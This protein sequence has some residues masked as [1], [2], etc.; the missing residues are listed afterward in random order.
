MKSRA[1]IRILARETNP[2]GDLFARLMADLFV[3]LG[4]N[5][6]RLNVHKT[7]RELDLVASHRL[8]RRRAIAEC[9]A[10]GDPIGGA[11][12]NKFV[13]ALDAEQDDDPVTGYFVSLGGFTETALEQERQR[14]KTKLVLLDGPQIVDQLI[15]GRILIPKELATNLAGRLAGSLADVALDPQMELLGHERGWFWAVYYLHFQTRSHFA[16]IRSDGEFASREIADELIAADRECGG[17]LHGLKILNPDTSASSTDDTEKAI[18]AYRRY[19][20]SECGFIQLDG[21]PADAE[22]A[23]HHLKLEALF[24]P[25]YLDILRRLTVGHTKKRTARRAVGSVL[26]KNPRIAL[27]APP[28]GGKSTLL[29]RLA[30]VYSD[31]KRRDQLPDGL[32]VRD[33]LPLFIRCRDLRPVARGTFGDMLDALCQQEPVRAQAAALRRYIDRELFAGRILLLVDG[34][35]E[36]ADPGDRA[37]F[38]CTLRATLLAYPEVATVISSR[39]AGF[40]HVAAH[41]DAVCT[42]TRL[43]PF[44]ANDVK[45]LT[46]AWSRQID[47][48]R[49]EVRK[50]AEAL[51]ETIVGNDRIQRLASNPLLLTTLLLVKRWV[52]TLP[53]R[54]TVLYGKAVEVLLMTWNVEGHEPIPEDEALPQL[55]FVAWAMTESGLKE[56]GRPRLAALL[57]EARETLPIELGHVQGSVDDFIRRVE[58]RSSLLMMT[59]HSVED[60]QLVEF[61]EFRHL[62]FQ[63]FLAARAAVQGWH[64]SAQDAQTLASALEPHL[65][66]EAWRE[67]VPL[68]AAMGGK[69]ADALIRTL[70]ERVKALQSGGDSVAPEIDPLCLVLGNCLADEAPGQPLTIRTALREL[71][72]LGSLDI[73]AFGRLLALGRYGGAFHDEARDAFLAGV[74]LRSAGR[75]WGVTLYWRAVDDEAPGRLRRALA[76]F[77]DMLCSDDRARRC[78]GALGLAALCPKLQDEERKEE[79]VA[80]TDLLRDAGGP[81]V[82]LLYADDFCEQWAAA[83]GMYELAT[84]RVWAPP[85]EPDALG[86]LFSLWQHS[87]NGGVRRMA[88]WALARQPICTRNTGRRCATVARAN[89][90]QLLATY[91]ALSRKREQPAVLAVAW[92]ARSLSDE[93]LASR[94]KTLLAVTD[95]RMAELTTR[96]LLRQLGVRADRE[97][98]A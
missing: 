60:G 6:P 46:L 39:E 96:E 29:K 25:M 31:H 69:A 77:K 47:G 35:D 7:G 11:D 33:W 78:A 97:R 81:L 43:S 56:I 17:L 37:A 13:G 22:V 30:I 58:D 57:H 72:R 28:G 1:S 67:V 98:V 52:G 19:I 4:Y 55:C 82:S 86:R 41:L 8:E 65:N 87:P 89:L 84:F 49:E 54:R 42:R 21:M 62:T 48:D 74:D 38:I 73:S 91:D 85:A 95:D 76:L 14:R 24:V 9:K 44:D 80:S 3:A 15:E 90:D 93:E 40:R 59:G 92:Y 27:L 26:R 79:R 68:A 5:A 61:F 83:W 23:S 70:T 34:I 18:E 16:L 50:A 51:A 32:P 53:T 75:A 64:H 12:I 10:T 45:R 63:E 36:I 20:A 2:R 71:I 94:A 88:G 66:D